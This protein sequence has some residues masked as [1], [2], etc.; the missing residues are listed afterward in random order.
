MTREKPHTVNDH[1]SVQHVRFARGRTVRADLRAN[2]IDGVLYSISVGMGETY[3]AK[4]VHEL[5]LGPVAVGLI[6]TVPVLVGAA[7]QTIGPPIVRRAGSF[8]GWVVGT[9]A[10][11]AAVLLPLIVLALALPPVLPAIHSLAYVCESRGQSSLVVTATWTLPAIVFGLISMYWG[12]GL[13]TSPA[14]NAWTGLLIPRPV[15]GHFFGIRTLQCQLG[16]MLGLLAGG[17]LLERAAAS[18]SLGKLAGFAIVFGFA[19]LFRF[20]SAYY[21]S[22]YSEPRELPRERRVPVRVFVTRVQRSHDGRFLAYVLAVM[23][24]AQVAQPFFNPYMFD[25]L[26]VSTADYSWLIAGPILGRVIAAPLAGI[27]AKRRG[28]RKCLEIGGIAIVPMSLVWLMGS[29]FWWLLF[30][31]VLT[32]AIWAMFEMGQQLLNFDALHQT[33]R[34]SLMTKFILTNEVSRTSGSLLGGKMLDAF[35]ASASG[36]AWVFW[37]SAAAR[38]AAILLLLRLRAAEPSRE[39]REATG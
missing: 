26:R 10:L 29:N 14:W 19:S 20:A 1:P 4:F 28:P 13:A 9:A 24:S 2:T 22:R 35:Q 33:E 15:R 25:I 32:G 21:L 31:Q 38:A 34:S 17:W 16:I 36:Y 7:L 18:Q 5:G 12:A 11:Q 37:A 3:F 30:A 8:R 23:F 6:L 27:V 39:S